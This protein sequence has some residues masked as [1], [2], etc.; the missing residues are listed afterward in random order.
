MPL[1][2]ETRAI[3]EELLEIPDEGRH[4]SRVG[5]LMPAMWDSS[6]FAKTVRPWCDA[7][8]IERIVVKDLRRYY[9]STLRERGVAEADCVA[10]M[11]HVN[12][13]MIRR[14]YHQ[15]SNSAFDQVALTL[16]NLSANMRHDNVVPIGK[17]SELGELDSDAVEEKA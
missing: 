15:G 2:P 8:G 11:G 3:V 7:L 5:Y 13:A 14:I 12:S 17:A 4:P 1:T 6:S 10:L 16:P 9:V